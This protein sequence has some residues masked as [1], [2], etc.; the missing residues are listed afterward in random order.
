MK[1]AAQLYAVALMLLLA[2]AWTQWT[3]EEPVDLEGKVVMLQG[4]ADA[5]EQVRWVSEDSE[6]TISR[7]NDARGDYFWVDYTRWTENKL[8]KSRAEASAD[9]GT[10]EASTADETTPAQPE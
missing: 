2:A 3:A 1:R 4:E 7:K 5:I 6:A 9:E 8:P 10:D